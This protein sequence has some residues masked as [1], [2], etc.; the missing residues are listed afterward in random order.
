[1]KFNFFGAYIIYVSW[2]VICSINTNKNS[3]VFVSGKSPGY[4]EKRK[5]Y[6]NVLKLFRKNRP[7]D[8]PYNLTN[9]QKKRYPT[10]SKYRHHTDKGD[11]WHINN[12]TADYSS[13]STAK[14]N[15]TKR[16]YYYNGIDKVGRPP[17]LPV[18]FQVKMIIETVYPVEGR[19]KIL[20]L[21]HYDYVNQRI[22]Y[23]LY[24]INE[25]SHAHRYFTMIKKFDEG[26]K[27]IVFH[28]V[29]K[30]PLPNPTGCMVVALNDEMFHPSLL[31]Y[32]GI[33]FGEHNVSIYKNIKLN[34]QQQLHAHGWALKFKDQWYRYYET[35]LTRKPVRLEWD[36]FNATV[37]H[38]EE[39]THTVKP[40][41]FDVETV[42]NVECQPFATPL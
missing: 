21:Y 20:C 29:R 11:P 38:L 34:E 35:E 8:N 5:Y 16:Y 13:F 1:M 12:P 39:G 19:V 42:T 28:R 26:K 14:K 32:H 30:G 6:D 2:F 33:Y 23:D 4:R 27:W 17:N 41:I 3:K 24:K 40:N 37:I 9:P 18:Q 25:N 15:K 31:H 36:H 10:K 22:R 7:K